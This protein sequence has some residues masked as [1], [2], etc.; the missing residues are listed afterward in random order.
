MRRS[1]LSVAL[2]LLLVFSSGVLVGALGYRFL[3]GS[4]PQP[5]PRPS[6]EEFK[7]RYMEEMRTRLRLS[8]E[9]A[10]QIETILD[11]TREKYRA[12]MRAFQE[13]QTSRIRAVLDE[14]QRAE[15]EKMRQ[16]REERRKRAHKQKP[17]P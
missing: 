5:P 12:H 11:E 3:A 8:D 16:E 6:P 13:E 7:R 10:R 17:E 4:P 15:Y 14:K 9:Q 1:R 2:Y